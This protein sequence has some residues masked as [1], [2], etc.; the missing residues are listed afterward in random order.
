MSDKMKPVPFQNLINWIYTE[1]GNHKTIFG[2]TSG[3]FFSPRKNNEEKI[4]DEEIENPIGPA[5]G[6]HTQLAQNII[7]AYLVGGSFFEL[8]TVQ[9]LDNL[10]IDKPC[11]DATDEGY[12]VE[13]SQE[14]S[15]DESYDEYVKAWF[16]IHLLKN[17]FCLSPSKRGFVF[18]MS[19]GY[20]LDGI[21]T[22][23][24][25]RFIEELKD[26]TKN[27][28]F[29]EYRTALINWLRKD[30]TYELLAKT[31]EINETKF[32]NIILNIENISPQISNSV[33]LS[34]MHGCPPQEIESIAK[35]LIQEKKLHTYVKLNPTLLGFDFVNDT[36]Q[37][38]GYKKINLD[39]KSFD[40]DLQYQDAIPMLNRLRAFASGNNRIFGIKLSNTLGVKNTSKVLPGADMY[41]SGRALFPLTINLA[42]KLAEE[43]DGEINISYSGGANNS[44]ILAILSTGIQPVTFATELLKPG[45]YERL[46]Q[47]ANNI[48]RNYSTS[49]SGSKLNI[50]RLKTFAEDS[51][52]NKIYS[53]EKREVDSIKIPK[54]LPAFDCYIAPCQDACPIHQDVAAYIK[55]VEQKRYEEA[56]EL[57]V[58]KNPLPHI[59]GYICDHQCMYH[60]TRWDYDEPVLIR[61]IKKEAA[62]NG[63]ESYFKKFN[64]T[65]IAKNEETKQ[66]NHNI[67][68][69]IIGA[70]PSGLSAGYFLAKAGFDVTIFEK[71]INAGGIVK[72]VL[73]K[74]R[75]PQEAIEKDIR[76]I[77]KHGVK[78]VFGFD[79][80]YPFEK[81]KKEGFHYIYIAIGA[82]LSNKMNLEGTHEN[83]FGAIEFLKDY[84]N[85]QLT[86]LGKSVAI[87]GG[88]NSAMDSARA[89][90]RYKG[91]EKVYLIYR[92]TKEQMPA[93]KEEFFAALKDGVEFKELLLPVKYEN[94]NLTCQKMK[95]DEIGTDGRRN[96]I[97]IENEFELVQVDSVIAAIGEHV[98]KDFL[99]R[100]KIR[101]AHNSAVVNE[102][103][104]T[105]VEN[106]FIGGDALRGPSTVV[107]SIADGKKAAEAI[108]KKEF[109]E[110]QSEHTKN[111]FADDSTLFEDIKKRKGHVANQN[112]LDFSS[113]ASRCLGC[114]FICNK[115]VEV[116][117]NRANVAIK[118]NTELLK[119][120]YQILHLDASCNECGN[121]ET[122][123][124]YQGAPYK[125]K[126]TL[127]LN[128]NDF[129]D[130]RN[131]GFFVTEYNNQK[132]VQIRWKSEKGIITFDEN[133]E[134]VKSSYFEQKEIET[135]TLWIKH[136]LWNYSYLII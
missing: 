54:N 108:I 116:C 112:S 117:P 132:T 28:L 120:K 48:K 100:N 75:L 11:I 86:S 26:A 63:Y 113:E 110:F 35:Y 9:K 95:L 98:D 131:N 127:F 76:F 111:Y 82:E 90:T 39:K 123:C 49:E 21:K 74:F 65:F 104:E 134:V 60:C 92:R 10:K 41:M 128:E 130:S 22:E 52:T 40:H 89:A 37:K 30:E 119:D 7:S 36:L 109:P 129:N 2:I 115:C 61:D 58:S 15:L 32:E 50:S 64:E 114:N 135:L 133:G 136:I 103:N 1:Y 107:E 73:P 79:P 13:W 43:F 99:H 6:P 25:D 57:I 33:T 31:F 27:E 96:T 23:R 12:N 87:I 55:L 56:Y 93:D 101:M 84:N 70:G 68:V 106:I 51:L 85:T 78:F 53:K 45:G 72:N 34:T 83:I 18:N 46:A 125:N 5:A 66:S 88:G 102:S 126:P 71:E 29:L 14:L 105:A 47:I 62:L 59:T 91:V 69:A 4:F 77:E 3:K 38:L 118:T 94:G 122:F 20:D 44:N 42:Y 16:I 124:P 17:L 24:M 81:L 97:P 19:V 67:N 80:N 121:C 8:K